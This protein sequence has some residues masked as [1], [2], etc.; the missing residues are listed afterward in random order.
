MQEYLVWLSVHYV[1]LVVTEYL[2]AFL[3]CPPRRV[4][5]KGPTE[6]ATQ[7]LILSPVL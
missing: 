5:L 3:H 7:N 6:L 2:P 4:Q 1:Y